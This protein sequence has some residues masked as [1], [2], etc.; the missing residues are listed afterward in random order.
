MS[1]SDDLSLTAEQ[2]RE[3]LMKDAANVELRKQYLAVRTPEL[4][5]LDQGGEKTLN[6]ALRQMGIGF[7][8]GAIGGVIAGLIGMGLVAYFGEAT[9]EGKGSVKARLFDVVILIGAQLGP[10]LLGVCAGIA[11]GLFGLHMF[12][13]ERMMGK[14][15]AELGPL[16]EGAP[17]DLAKARKQFLGE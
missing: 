6:M 14:I 2:L 13:H 11:G 9:F 8:L 17:D 12:L 4:R 10:I 1:M 5:D 15:A 16:P 7:L 3:A